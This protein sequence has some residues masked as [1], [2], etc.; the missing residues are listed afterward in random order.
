MDNSDDQQVTEHRERSAYP[1]RTIP[2]R[3]TADKTEKE[4]ATAEITGPGGFGAK[5]SGNVAIVAMLAAAICVVV[6]Y[7]IQQHDERSTAAL[8]RVEAATIR[9]A[10]VQEAMLWMFT[11]SQEER[12]ALNL[13]KPE[14]LRDME[15]NR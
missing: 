5:V 9:A 12:E 6:G 7:Y 4:R 14:V 3:R 2:A 13:S 11:K 15:K 1:R 10:K 8:A